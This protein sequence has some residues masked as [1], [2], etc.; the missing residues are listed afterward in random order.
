MSLPFRNKNTQPGRQFGSN[1]ICFAIY[2]RHLGLPSLFIY[3]FKDYPLSIKHDVI[4]HSPDDVPGDF[5]GDHV[6]SHPA[7]QTGPWCHG[8]HSM[9]LWAARWFGRFFIF[10]DKTLTALTSS[11]AIRSLRT[12]RW[13]GSNY[14]F[15]FLAKTNWH[16]TEPRA[17]WAAWAWAMQIFSQHLPAYQRILRLPEPFYILISLG[18]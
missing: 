2:A 11:W 16:L 15:F 6:F 14:R 18:F 9:G 1:D 8:I 17:A 12:S 5:R 7:K 13:R 10:A 3:G 4:E